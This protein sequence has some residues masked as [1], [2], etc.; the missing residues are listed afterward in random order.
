MP[1]PREAAPLATPPLPLL[2][3]WRQ[4]SAESL[5]FS[6]EEELASH[7]TAGGRG[8]LHSVRQFRL[9]SHFAPGISRMLVVESGIYARSGAP[10]GTWIVLRKQEYIR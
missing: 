9:H 4:E 7:T 2:G 3:E 1:R 6:Y 8:Y 10:L 5:L